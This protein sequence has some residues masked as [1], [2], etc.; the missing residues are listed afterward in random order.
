MSNMSQENASAQG[1]PPL[2]AQKILA[3]LTGAGAIAV[4]AL[5]GAV[6]PAEYG[7]DP[8]GVGKATGLIGLHR[9][10][11]VAPTSDPAVKQASGVQQAPWRTLSLTI[12]LAAGGDLA[13]KDEV[14]YKLA[15]QP[16]QTMVYSWHVLTPVSSEEFYSDFHGHTVTPGQ[17]TTSAISYREAMGSAANGSLTAG[18]DGVHGWYFQNQSSHPVK[19]KLTVAGFF[20]VVPAGRPGNEAGLT[21]IVV[22]QP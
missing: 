19:M 21:A 7:W 14:E 17:E 22:P 8:L 15:M 16:G 10:E 1:A 18:F 13:R 2:T 6:F 5:V 4:V 20:D 11:T 9:P 3:L 12:A